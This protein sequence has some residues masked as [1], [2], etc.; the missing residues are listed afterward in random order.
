MGKD[1]LMH[2]IGRGTKKKLKSPSKSVSGGKGSF[3]VS[4]F[5]RF[6]EILF[7]NANIL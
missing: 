5:L 1:N 7:E 3:P 4:W 2:R 6:Y